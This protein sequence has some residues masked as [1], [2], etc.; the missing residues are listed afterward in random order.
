MY[1][2]R[3]NSRREV[4]LKFEN[5]EGDEWYIDNDNNI[6]KLLRIKLI[7]CLLFLIKVDGMQVSQNLWEI[8]L[9]ELFLIQFKTYNLQ[10]Q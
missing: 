6:Q 3:G 8:L 7:D 9:K 5:I 2:L 1:K 10:M 4:L